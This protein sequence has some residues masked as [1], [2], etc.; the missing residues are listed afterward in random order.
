MRPPYQNAA[1]KPTLVYAGTYTGAKSKGIY[2][3]SLKT[4]NLEVEQNITLVP[5]GLAVEAANPSFLTID[6][7][8]RLVFAVNEIDRFEDKPSGAVSAFSADA[9]TGKLTLLNQRPSMGTGPCHLALDKEGRNLLVANY[10]SGS[11]AVLPVAPMGDS[12]RPRTSCNTPAKASI[13]IANKDRMRT[14]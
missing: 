6:A 13:P 9:A 4:T 2:F 1:M 5:L 11:V 14:A 10:G 12:D 7:R 3:F 8:R